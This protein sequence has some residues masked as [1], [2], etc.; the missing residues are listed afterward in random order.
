MAYRQIRRL[1][2]G[3]FGEVWLEE[4][5]GLGRLCAAKYLEPSRLAPGSFPYAEAQAMMAAKH[6]NVVQIFSAEET[7]G[8][9]VIRMEYLEAGSVEDRYSGLPI[10]VRD[11]VRLMEEACRGVEHLHSR[12]LLHR[13][14]KPG[15]LLLQA[16][17]AV[18]LSDFGLS[19]FTNGSSV[20]PPWS[21]TAH[22]PPEALEADRGID[23]AVGDVYALG[24]TAYRLLN[25]DREFESFR[26]SI[27]SKGSV[28]PDGW[29]PHV[30]PRLRR[31]VRK[32]MHAQPASRYQSAWD[33]RHGLE[34]ARP[35]VSWVPEGPAEGQSW[36]GW[37]EIGDVA[38]RA[39]IEPAA[40]NR[41]AFKVERAL[42]GK[43]WRRIVRDCDS[44]P[45]LPGATGHAASV[46][47]RI[48]EAGR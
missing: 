2:A 17:G 13:D 31:V 29:L 41:W 44:F 47:G 24:I 34:A 5:E 45:G 7:D 15:N 46:L 39:A 1:G 14:I 35:V 19:C 27:A 12:G 43:G 22:L 26:A 48:A 18:K 6:E 23:S 21:Y 25:G 40:R 38:W 9:P 28:V 3:Y 37:A 36:A 11:A 20:V 42:N 4:D 8:V 10:A 30:H 33:F 32:A 16:G